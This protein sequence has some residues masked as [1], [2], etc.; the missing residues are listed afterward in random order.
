MTIQSR[1]WRALFAVGIVA[2]VGGIVDPMEGSL[3]IL[4]A[5]VITLGALFLGHAERSATAYWMW[6]AVGMVVGVGALWGLS[7]VGGIGGNSGRSAWWGLSMLPYP[8][9]WVAGMRW[10]VVQAINA[11]RQKTHA[12]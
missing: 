10:L 8:V 7:S 11:R 3:V 4:A 6:V 1:W 12:A 9:A 5:S 2:F